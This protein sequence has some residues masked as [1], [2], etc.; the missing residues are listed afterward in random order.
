MRLSANLKK[1]GNKAFYGCVDLYYISKLPQTLTSIGDRAFYDCMSLLSINIPSGVTRI[2]AKTFYEC[3]SLEKISLSKNLKGIGEGAFGE[4]W[5]LQSI[6][7]PDG[8]KSIGA[9]AFNGCKSLETISFPRSLS[10]IGEAAFDNVPWLDNAREEREDGL[11][12]I[13]NIL[14]DGLYAEFDLIIPEQI[15]TIVKE[16]FLANSSIT[17]IQIPSGVTILEDGFL[18][19]CRD[20]KKVILPDKL[21][22]IGDEAFLNVHHLRR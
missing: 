3:F 16:A 8:L 20:L 13:N 6:K 21:E 15:D 5:F 18:S 4:C 14:L 9:N 7:L 2:G 22:V 17:S 12:I 19:E 11:V 1:I 10:Y